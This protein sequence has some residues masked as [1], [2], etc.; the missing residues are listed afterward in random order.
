MSATSENNK[1]IAKNT[2]FLYIRMLIIMGVTLYTSRVVL[3]KLGIDDYGLYNVVGGVVGMLSFVN[4]TLSIGTSRFLTFELGKKDFSRLSQT[5][6]TAFYTHLGLGLV[7]VLILETVGL[8]FVYNKLV[9]PTSRFH[10]ALIVYQ[11]SIFTSLIDITQVPYTSLIMAHEKMGVYAYVSIFEAFG[12][13]LVVFLLSIAP[14]DKLIA[15]SI[16]LAMVQIAIA[17]YYR[18]YCVRH[19]RESSFQLSYDKNIL[20]QL[21]GFSG[22][23]ILA[24]LAETL[25]MQGYLILLNIFF[26]SAIVAAQTIGNQVAGAMM[27]FVN[28]FRTAINPQ[29]IKQYAAGDYESSKKLTLDTTIYVF[30]LVL[31][32]GLPTI[33]TL[34]TIMNIWLVKVPPYAVLFTQYIIVQ[35]I[36]STFDSAFYIPMLAAAKIKTNSIFASLSGPG[37]FLFLYFVYKL[38]GNVMWMQYIGVVVQCAFGFFIKPYLLG[39]DVIGYK[40]TDFFPCFLSCG[41]VALLSLVISYLVYF[42]VGNKTLTSSAILF[43]MSFIGVAFASY[44]FLEKDVRNKL[45]RILLSKIHRFKESR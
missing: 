14:F 45:N 31:L 25:K 42:L 34:N 43:V 6:N 3:A 20:K 44:V 39:K 35:R 41:K 32:L 2:I 33:F 27:Q 29:I 30:D 9:I 40:K 19:F 5:F 11:V 12:K 23:N 18:F 26:S 38:G 1:R 28:N 15:Y 36:L 10:A 7:L 8:W 17:G 24:N 22:W 13:L 4:G 16:L 21:L 37:M